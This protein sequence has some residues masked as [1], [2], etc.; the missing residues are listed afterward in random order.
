[1]RDKNVADSFQKF[2]AALFTYYIYQL[3]FTVTDWPNDR[4]Y[5]QLNGQVLLDKLLSRI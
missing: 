2:G 4:R 1:M 5:K 3:I